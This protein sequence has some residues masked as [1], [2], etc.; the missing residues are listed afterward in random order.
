LTNRGLKTVFRSRIGKG[1]SL[2]KK[3]GKRKRGNENMVGW[4]AKKKL[5]EG[6]NYQAQERHLKLREA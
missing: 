5:W 3:G 6:R 2:N 1:G 4:S